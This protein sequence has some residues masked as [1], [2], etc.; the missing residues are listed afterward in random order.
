MSMGT[1]LRSYY[2]GHSLVSM[3]DGQANASRYYHFDHQGTTQCLTNEAGVVTDRFAADA[4]GVEVKRTG[5]SINRHWYIGNW[6]YSQTAVTNLYYV[7]ARLLNAALGRWFSA[8]RVIPAQNRY[9][10]TRN[11]PGSRIDP[12]GWVC[13]R[14]GDT[15]NACGKTLECSECDPFGREVVDP[16]CK[17]VP[18]GDPKCEN[19]ASQLVQIWGRMRDVATGVP[20]AEG[21]PRAPGLL[22][23]GC[24]RGQP[25][26][27]GMG[28]KPTPWAQTDCCVRNGFCTG[29][30]TCMDCGSVPEGARYSKQ[31]SCIQACLVEHEQDHVKINAATRARGRGSHTTCW[32]WSVRRM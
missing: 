30:I 14:P 17:S 11:R 5:S 28:K 2:R 25:Q 21:M 16:S 4:W 1:S 24:S 32:E 7:R 26:N 15:C 29:K 3:R 23:I 13:T 27:P 22:Q 31:P 6:G 10:Y 19:G 18:C 12:L 9:W 20:P 8:D